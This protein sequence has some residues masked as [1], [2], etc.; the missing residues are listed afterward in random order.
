MR[1]G[2][3]HVAESDAQWLLG[4]I[5]RDTHRHGA[6]RGQALHQPVAGSPPSAL[7]EDAAGGFHVGLPG[8]LD[9]VSVYAARMMVCH[10]LHIEERHFANGVRTFE[11]DRCL[12]TGRP[13]H[14][15]FVERQ[16][17]GLGGGQ[18]VYVGLPSPFLGPGAPLFVEGGLHSRY[19]RRSLR[20]PRLLCRGGLAVAGP[21]REEPRHEAAR[22]RRPRSDQGD[23]KLA[24]AGILP[25]AYD[26]IPS[27][28]RALC[29]GQVV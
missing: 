29:P 9:G 6:G 20:L 10:S 7:V 13:G 25:W 12:S 28:G 22:Y 8:I 16:M 2:S 3:A 21:P 14:R 24:H 18:E 15:V 5:N 27:P 11:D 17:S 4:R 19:Q 26:A 23:L 1:V